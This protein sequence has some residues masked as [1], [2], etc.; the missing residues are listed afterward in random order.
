MATVLPGTTVE[1]SKIEKDASRTM[2]SG[3]F[4]A[5]GL[6]LSQVSGLTGLEPYLIQNWV[7]RGFVSSPQKRMYSEN[8]FARIC[9][10][11]MLRESLQLDR[12]IELLQYINGTLNDESDDLIGDAELYHRYVGMLSN[13]DAPLIDGQ[14]IKDAAI[15]ASVG[16][17]SPLPGAD[18]RLIDVLTVMAYAHFA[19]MARQKAELLLQGFDKM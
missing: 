8:Q 1:V 12:I 9:I 19:T 18:R 14:K 17:V 5:G 11:N 6:T 15:T 10:I 16:F 13:M 7:K 2:W 4:A 3:M